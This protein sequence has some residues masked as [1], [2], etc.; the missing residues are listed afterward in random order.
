MHFQDDFTEIFLYNWI[1]TAGI[2][3]PEHPPLAQ[4]SFASGL[5]D[6][7]LLSFSPGIIG[8]PGFEFQ[9]VSGHSSRRR[10]TCEIARVR[11]RPSPQTRRGNR[12]GQGG[13]SGDQW[14]GAGLR[15][16]TR[17]PHKATHSAN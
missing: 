2:L 11:K 4:S 13:L 16:P 17:D 10:A 6:M 8:P 1:R 5:L 15:G 3:A 7:A 14:A 9:R 12:K